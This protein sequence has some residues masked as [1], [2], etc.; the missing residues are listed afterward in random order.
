MDQVVPKERVIPQLAPGK[1]VPAEQVRIIYSVTIGPGIQ[2]DDLLVPSFW[3]LYGALL[4]PGNKIEVH[5]EDGTWYAEYLVR[6]CARTWAKVAQT[7]FISFDKA[8]TQTSDKAVQEAL[9]LYKVIHRG[10]HKWSVLRNADGAVMTQSLQIR[11]EAESWL[12]TFVRNEL[13]VK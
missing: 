5:P 10:P 8:E 13:G 1:M 2:I 11:D 6:D 9:A 3:S 12:R 7:F 4:V